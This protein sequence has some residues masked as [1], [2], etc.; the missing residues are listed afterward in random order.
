MT[1]RPKFRPA[2][3]ADI[4]HF[5]GPDFAV[6]FRAS[7]VEVDGELL[8]VGGLYYTPHTAIGFAKYDDKLAEFPLAKARGALEI[9]K[10]IQGRACM[11][12]VDD[13]PESAVVLEKL[14][15]KHVEGKIWK[16]MI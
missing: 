2:T 8:G 11:A 15:W 6:S 14:G 13:K 4:E 16:W 5:Y 3:R 10:H 7:A 9:M 1:K 12:I